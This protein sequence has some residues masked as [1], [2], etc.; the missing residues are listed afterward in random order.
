MIC[1][2]VQKLIDYAIKKEL[3]TNDDIYVVRN[4]LME[5]LKLTDWEENLS[6]CSDETIEEI[7]APLVKYACEKGIISD[8]SNS[9]DLFDTKLM[10]I[11][12]YW[13]LPRPY[14]APYRSTNIRYEQRQTLYQ[15]D[16]RK[17]DY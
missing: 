4:Q 5:A 17:G 11:L 15:R 12:M 9:H 7:L 14:A 2:D 1:N 3:I 16:L 6:E 13:G 10:G 8:T